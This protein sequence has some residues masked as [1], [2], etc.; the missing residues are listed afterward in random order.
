MNPPTRFTPVKN[1]KAKMGSRKFLSAFS[2]PELLIVI[3][4]IGILATIGIESYQG[5]QASA[6]ESIARDNLALLNRAVLHY[7]QT[8]SDVTVTPTSGSATDEL[9]ILSTLKTRDPAI[10]GSPYLEINFRDTV[11]AASDTYRI[12]WNGHAFELLTPGTAGTGLL[13]GE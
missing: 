6:H 1:R 5:I 10:P 9:A 2:L 13:T 11:S 8:T 3:A 7:S 4:T 12:Q